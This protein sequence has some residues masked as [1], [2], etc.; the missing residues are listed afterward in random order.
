M[1]GGAA[2]L[3][4]LIIRFPVKALLPFSSPAA[5]QSE[6]EIKG[7]RFDPRFKGVIY[8]NLERSGFPSFPFCPRTAPLGQGLRSFCN[9]RGF[10]SPSMFSLI[11][12]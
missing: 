11:C 2:G 6:L 7:S 3:V 5:R 9:V 12:L 10:P 1:A 8:R 4:R